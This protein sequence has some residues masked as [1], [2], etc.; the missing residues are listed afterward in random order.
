M[1]PPSAVPADRSR[2]VSLG[3]FFTVLYLLMTGGRVYSPD[4]LV[5]ARTTESIVERG[6]LAVPDPGY[7][8]GFLTSGRE[9]RRYSKYGLGMPVL[10]VPFFALGKGLGSLASEGTTEQ[11]FSGPRFLWYDPRDPR[12]SW[13]FFGISLTAAP[14]TAGAVALLFLLG[15]ELDY[16]GRSSLV[17]AGVAGLASPLLVYAKTFFSEP[18]SALGVTFAVLAGIRWLRRRRLRTALGVGVGLSVAALAKLAHLILVPVIVGGLLWRA[19]R[20]G[21]DRREI[22]RGGTGMLAGLVPAALLLAAANLARF[23]TVLATGYGQETS[24]FT[25]P[26]FEGLRGLLVSPGRGLLIYFPLVVIALLVLP[27]LRSRSP[28]V[29]LVSW[30]S[31]AVLLGLYA[32]WHGWDGGWA[33]GPRFL[34]PLVP[35]LVLAAAPVLIG[36]GAS[37]WVRIPAW[38]AVAWGA[39]VN[40]I[41]TLVPFTE[42]HDALRGAFGGGYLPLAR[43]SWQVWAPR[44]YLQ[45]PKDYWIL[46]RVLE[47]PGVWWLAVLFGIG[48]GVLPFLA[49]RTID[50][51][52]Y[53]ASVRSWMVGVGALTAGALFGAVAAI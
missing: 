33:W 22:V 9:G 14:L 43:W 11:L 30:G 51:E 19:W 45:M 15:R 40:W 37:L 53:G 6:E 18:L 34:V 13:P 23:G 7:P 52:G 12:E 25:V 48:A 39:L 26:L 28:A 36:E 10:G 29:A 44:A 17:L 2:A 24:R 8:E 31:L 16:G 41:G 20:R 32:R 50:P 47:T 21:M 46:P 35:L 38:I 4:A 42:Y 5:M 27:R 1:S 3:L 49:W